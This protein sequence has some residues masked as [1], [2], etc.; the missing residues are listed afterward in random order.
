MTHGNIRFNLHIKM[1]WH[2]SD[3]S[4]QLEVEIWQLTLA[5]IKMMAHVFTIY[6]DV[7]KQQQPQAIKSHW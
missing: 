1:L 6:V 5:S 4:Y 3:Y 7:C 2:T